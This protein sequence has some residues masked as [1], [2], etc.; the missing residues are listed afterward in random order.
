MGRRGVCLGF[1]KNG[2]NLA[3]ELVSRD[4]PVNYVRLIIKKKQDK[5]LL[6]KTNP[7]A[8]LACS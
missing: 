4:R 5:V 2:L 8:L 3:E 6:N 7:T 1:G